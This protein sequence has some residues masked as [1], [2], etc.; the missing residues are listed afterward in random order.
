MNIKDKV[1]SDDIERAKLG[2]EDIFNTEKEAD[3]EI[4][5]FSDLDDAFNSSDFGQG[6]G[7]FH[8]LPQQTSNE[9]KIFDATVM[10]L[11]G[12]FGFLKE[13]VTSFS[14]FNT[15]SRLDTGRTIVIIS[16]IVCIVGVIAI[17][18]G[19][20]K[21]INLIISSFLS[22][23]IGIPLFYSA[24]IDLKVKNNNEGT[25][26]DLDEESFQ[27]EDFLDE[28]EEFIEE[29]LT[30][31]EYYD[32]FQDDFFEDETTID[33]EV[34]NNRELVVDNI[35]TGFNGMFTRSY[36]YE[37]ISNCLTS[38]NPSF[39]K[40]KTFNEEDINFQAWDAII[41]N[42]AQIL[43]GKN[44]DVEPMYLISLQEKLFYIYLSVKRPNWLK[45]VDSLV[46]EIIN[47][48]AFNRE[49]G[50]L[51]ENI[52]GDGVSV[53][54]TINIKIMKDVSTMVSLRDTYTLVEKEILN[55]GNYIPVVL[56]IDTEG[57]VVFKDLKNVESLLIAGPPRSGKTWVALSIICQI[58]AY[59]S[60]S[61]AQ[62]YIFDPKG[63]LS[64]YK[65]LEI[66]HVKKFIT[67]TEDMLGILRDVVNVEGAYRQDLIG[68]AGE[69]NI[70][71]YKKKNPGV[72]LPLLYIVIDEVITVAESMPKEVKAEFQSL[73][74]KLVTRLPAAGI[75]IIML[76]HVIK[77]EILSKTL[78]DNI[79][80]RISVMGSA[81]HIEKSTG[82]KKFNH[83][84]KNKGDLA[85]KFFN[86]NAQ[87]VHASVLT[88]SNNDNA[89]FFDFLS[90]F[91]LKLEPD[92][93]EDSVKKAN[94][95]IHTK[96][97]SLNQEFDEKE[98]DIW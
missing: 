13:F 59:L 90:K 10:F 82:D 57:C 77:H 51:N 15:T 18:F 7:E 16:I 86:D 2:R 4:D 46:K 11:K 55:T 19:K 17:M 92:S 54:D 29:E 83:K 68:D 43:G 41:Q 31:D 44:K 76:P 78:T 93:Y 5:M 24:Y 87:F 22:S 45:N 63:K 39:N 14:N 56:G 70:W 80:C 60:P 89:K 35:N 34:E 69:V 20:T 42:S 1:S 37:N 30:E 85:V 79:P 58:S 96:K 6:L 25:N 47:I 98:F 95:E 8:Q 53:G 81:E 33:N 65:A 88:K 62:F 40:V 48:Y 75:R 91:W 3:L 12:L 61:E 26:N 94:E 9:E 49:T 72:K 36:L 97:D 71:D 50:I 67:K 32:Y 21:G 38:I 52:Y 23:S 66:P 74:I 64:D 27:S 73:L 28:D 84:L